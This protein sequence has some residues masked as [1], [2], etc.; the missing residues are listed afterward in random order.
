M[1]FKAEEMTEDREDKSVLDQ[2]YLGDRETR[3]ERL[4]CQ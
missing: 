2:L 4:P 1:S 3:S